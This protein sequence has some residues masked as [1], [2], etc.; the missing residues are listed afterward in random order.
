MWSLSQGNNLDRRR[1]WTSVNHQE[2]VKITEGGL[3]PTLQNRRLVCGAGVPP[4]PR[5]NPGREMVLSRV[6]VL[7]P[8][9]RQPY[10]GQ[11]FFQN[12]CRGFFKSIEG[13]LEACRYKGHRLFR[14][15]QAAKNPCDELKTKN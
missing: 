5:V 9:R 13:K 10:K 8:A 15:I 4:A 7:W 12:K 3:K 14:N 1:Q 11:S 6:V 2:P